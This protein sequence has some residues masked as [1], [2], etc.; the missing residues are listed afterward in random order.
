MTNEIESF[1]LYGREFKSINVCK[2]C[3]KTEPT[4]I[5]KMYCV[6]CLKAHIKVSRRK[7]IAKM[8]QKNVVK[9]VVK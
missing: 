2:T 1:K 8:N 5:N 6:G 7:N 3:G 4:T 9:I